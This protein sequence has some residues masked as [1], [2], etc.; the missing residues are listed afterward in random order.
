MLSLK[1]KEYGIR[2]YYAPSETLAAANL[3]SEFTPA[4]LGLK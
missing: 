1:L 2:I 3:G 4:A